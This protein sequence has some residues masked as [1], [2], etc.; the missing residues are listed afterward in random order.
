MKHGFTL[1]ELLLV[2][3]LLGILSIALGPAVQ[4]SVK[5]YDMV[6]TRRQ[7]V[8]QARAGMDRMIKEIQLIPSSPNIN[9]TQ[10]TDFTFRY[11]GSTQVRYY[12]SGTNVT[13]NNYKLMEH[14]S[15]LAF[16]YYDEDSI[17][18]TISNRVRSVG[19]QITIDPETIIPDFTLRTR[20][21]VRNTGNNYTG[22]DIE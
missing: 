21:F 12:L 13:R 14:V 8:A 4:E 20:V 17:P 16:T 9:V 11:P 2:V 18:T 22:Y 7:V 10:T 19:I 5:G 1:I 3:A 15:S 6:W